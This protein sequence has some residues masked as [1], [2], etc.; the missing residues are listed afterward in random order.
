MELYILMHI[1]IKFEL[2]LKKK[3]L[4][5]SP[6]IMHLILDYCIDNL[7]FNHCYKLKCI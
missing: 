1:N 5:G 3:G 6:K 2:T 7:F 4:S